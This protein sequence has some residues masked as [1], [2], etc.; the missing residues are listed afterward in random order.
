MLFNGY[1]RSRYHFTAFAYCSFIRRG[2]SLADGT[3]GETP[4]GYLT[5]S[6]ASP[7]SNV[8][9]EQLVRADNR[10]WVQHPP[11]TPVHPPTPAKQPPKKAKATNNARRKKGYVSPSEKEEQAEPQRAGR[12]ARYKPVRHAVEEETSD[13][14]QL[15]EEPPRKR[16]RMAPVKTTTTR[17]GRT[18][19]AV[20][21]PTVG[22]PRGKRIKLYEPEPERVPTGGRSTRASRRSG[23]VGD[24]WEPIPDEWLNPDA[25]GKATNG[26]GK[27]K[28]KKGKKPSLEEESELS[29][30]SDVGGEEESDL[31]SISSSGLSDM[32]GDEVTAPEEKA[33]SPV[34]GLETANPD[35]QRNKESTDDVPNKT[36]NIDIL[37]LNGPEEGAAMDVDEPET[38]P[39]STNQPTL[40]VTAV[41]SHAPS[42]TVDNLTPDISIPGQDRPIVPDVTADEQVATAEEHGADISMDPVAEQAVGNDGVAVECFQQAEGP[43]ESEVA[44]VAEEQPVSSKPEP[45]VTLPLQQEPVTDV[46][47]AD[48]VPEQPINGDEAKT[49]L[50][51]LS[52][53]VAE[54]LDEE[55]DDP[56]DEV[57][58]I[59]KR[60]RNPDYLEWEL[61]SRF[62]FFNNST[63]LSAFALPLGLRI[64][65]RMGAV[66][67]AVRELAQSG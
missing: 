20:Q 56:N 49:V 65:L 61:V 25:V 19:K 14:E 42:N 30:L 9:A 16:G 54:A 28:G 58:A 48:T 1:V 62:A 21:E 67:Q 7:S 27:V 11:P 34:P 36:E 63:S 39:S 6:R 3:R 60:A 29:E 45:E 26:K 35:G 12:K 50:Q 23:I 33:Q 66:P 43:V 2:S 24:Q 52:K 38:D 22:T 51:E 10:L 4:T 5:V 59:I 17:Y 44:T 53:E 31:T 55:E 15:D 37:P 13:A 64:S 32:E 41:A 18:S 8:R 40:D 57:R 47:M 46:P